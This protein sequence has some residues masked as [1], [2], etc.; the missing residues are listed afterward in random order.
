MSK[1]KVKEITII[2]TSDHESEQN[3]ET[4]DFFRGALPNIVKKGFFI[5]F[6]IAYTKEKEKYD[7]MGIKS[8]PA[9]VYNNTVISTISKVKELF[10]VLLKVDKPVQKASSAEDDVDSYFKGEILIPEE[11]EEEDDAKYNAIEADRA[12]KM[13]FEIARRKIPTSGQKATPVEKKSRKSSSIKASSS[14]NTSTADVLL[15]LSG[16]DADDALMA[17]F[18]DN[19]EE[20][21]I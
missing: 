6:V 17:K 4:L 19:L 3:V 7:K 16:K 20:T 8:F 21:A 18:Y 10:D 1:S 14:T 15:S 2:F 5:N 11:D 13:Q 9:A 12:E